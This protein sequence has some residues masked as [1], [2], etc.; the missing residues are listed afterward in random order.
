MT[1]HLRDK[2]KP[3]EIIIYNTIVSATKEV[4]VG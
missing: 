2:L 1:V 4:H 3:L